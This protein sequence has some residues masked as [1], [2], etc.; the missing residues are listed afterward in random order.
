M[1]LANYESDE[2]F[3]PNIS[4]KGAVSTN[5]ATLKVK[6]PSL[7]CEARD[8]GGHTYYWN[9]KTNESTWQKPKE[10]FMKL[11]EYERI[12][13]VALQ[14]QEQQKYDQMKHS[15]DNADEI[16][17]KYR[18]EQLKKY[19]KRTEEPK[20]VEEAS[21]SYVDQYGVRPSGLGKWE[22]VVAKPEAEPLDLE[23]PEQDIQY[24]AIATKAE[25]PPVKKFKEKTITKLDDV[26]DEVSTVFKKRKFGSRNIRK[27]TDDS[28]T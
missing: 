23:L 28:T 7:W 8:D 6:D 2:E 17:S 11:A 9:V 10:G 4:K 1:A 26:G 20:K 15:I 24:I 14:Q 21:T 3:G 25:E 22:T 13:E 12:N 18:R 5:P 16:A 27:T 19:Q